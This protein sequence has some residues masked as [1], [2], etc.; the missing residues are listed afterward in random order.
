[1]TTTIGIHICSIDEVKYIYSNDGIVHSASHT[2]RCPHPPPPLPLPAASL[3]YYSIGCL[4][5]HR[6]PFLFSCTT[7]RY[8]RAPRLNFSLRFLFPEVLRQEMQLW[9]DGDVDY[10]IRRRFY[11]VSSDRRRT[12]CKSSACL[13]ASDRHYSIMSRSS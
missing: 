8:D 12:T 7:G 6:C 9:F 1:M 11:F 13:S 2:S 4:S 3:V 10:Q 5:T